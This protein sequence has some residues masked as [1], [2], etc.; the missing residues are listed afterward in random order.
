M[1][2]WGHVRLVASARSL[3]E[4]LSDTSSQEASPAPEFRQDGGHTLPP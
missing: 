2:N 4:G 3:E 1:E